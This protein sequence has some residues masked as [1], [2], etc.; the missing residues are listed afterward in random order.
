MANDNAYFN[1][2]S[3]KALVNDHYKHFKVDSV[4]IDGDIVTLECQIT[5]ESLRYKPLVAKRILDKCP[6]IHFV[7]F[8]GGWLD[9]VFTRTTLERY[10]HGVQKCPKFGR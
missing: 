5:P 10:R 1:T 4:T 8:T 7:H 6:S 3:I 9:S 2:D